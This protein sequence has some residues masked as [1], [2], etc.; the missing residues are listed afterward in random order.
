MVSIE[1]VLCPVTLPAELDGALRYAT[2]LARAYDAHLLLC[3][4]AGTPA[5]LTSEETSAEGGRYAEIKKTMADALVPLIERSQPEKLQ[6]EVIVADG[7]EDVGE[8]IVRAG[9]ERQVDL[10]VM[11]ARRSHTAA[12]L[13]S[14]AE[15]VSHGFLPGP[16]C[17]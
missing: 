13:G 14:T 3:H 11:R 2:S 5:L 12:M 9:R 16:D 15:Q 4:C 17:P 1:R 10:M 8:E 7:G 6:L